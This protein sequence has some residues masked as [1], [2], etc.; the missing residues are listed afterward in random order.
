MSTKSDV[1]RKKSMA[2]KELDFDKVEFVHDMK[3]IDIVMDYLYRT[4]DVDFDMGM[5]LVYKRGINF[6]VLGDNRRP[7]SYHKVNKLTLWLHYAYGINKHAIKKAL[8]LPMIV[9]KSMFNIAKIIFR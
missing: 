4:K 8:E 3:Q 1:K 6:Y 2:V 5:A 7:V 9:P